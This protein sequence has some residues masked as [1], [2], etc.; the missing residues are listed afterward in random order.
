MRGGFYWLGEATRPKPAPEGVM[1]GVTRTL[2]AMVVLL[3][4]CMAVVAAP[5]PVGQ[6]SP[7]DTIEQLCDDCS[8]QP[9]PW[10]A[11][12]C[13]IS[14]ICPQMSPPMAQLC[15]KDICD[16]SNP[17]SAESPCAAAVETTC[18]CACCVLWRL[19][20]CPSGP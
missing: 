13:D 15:R 2:M 11:S 17:T 19:Q 7:L 16:A 1:G 4:A 10:T 3:M 8:D 18:A 14:T 5:G 20:C 6:G 12:S 9:L